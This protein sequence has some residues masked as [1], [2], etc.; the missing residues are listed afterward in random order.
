MEPPEPAFPAST[1][2]PAI[3]RQVMAAGGFATVLAKGSPWGGALLIVHR[4][5]A[6]VRAYEK[7]P[8]LYGG[9]CWK[10]AAE[11]EEAVDRFVAAQRR[12]DPDLWVLEL[13]VDD[14][15]RF[16]PGLPPAD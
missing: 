7:L 10:A 6:M 12:F 15:A 2:V 3:S 8:S 5:Q 13:D 4:R 9:P 11:G 16:V 1:L 14:P